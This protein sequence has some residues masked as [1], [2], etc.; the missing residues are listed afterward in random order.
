LHTG[1]Y[2]GLVFYLD[3]LP[4]HHVAPTVLHWIIGDTIAMVVNLSG[5]HVP[6]PKSTQKACAVFVLQAFGMTYARLAVD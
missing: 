5:L 3:L 2:A 4:A 1:S 6:N